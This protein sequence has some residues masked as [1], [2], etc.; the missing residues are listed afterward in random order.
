MTSQHA[1]RVAG[2]DRARHPLDP[3]TADE[4]RQ[5]VSILASDGRV[6]SA[7]RFVSVGLR[8]PSKG[9]IASFRPGQAVDRAAY[10]VAREPREH[11]T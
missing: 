1:V 3:L 8:E 6:S 2:A 7:L 11:M 10:I 5:A 4:I 9:E